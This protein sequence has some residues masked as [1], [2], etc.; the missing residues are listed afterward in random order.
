MYISRACAR[1]RTGAAGLLLYQGQGARAS[2][3]ASVI[4]FT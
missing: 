1:D 4:W 2:H 3:P